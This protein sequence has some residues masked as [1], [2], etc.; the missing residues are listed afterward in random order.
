MRAALVSP[1]SWSFPGGVTRHV[2]ELAAEL[3]AQ[4]HE[5]RVLSPVDPDDRLTRAVHRRRPERR[6]LPDY[7]VP[8]GRT[9]ALAAN[10]AV[11]NLSFAPDAAVRLRNE[12]RAGRFDVVHV[13]E[14]IAPVI[15][16]DACCFDGS[17]VVGTFHVYSTK[18][19]PKGAA[20]VQGARGVFNKLNAR[21]AVSEAARWTGERYF[22]GEYQVI[23]NGVDVGAAP[24]GPRPAADHLRVLFVGR[25]E[26][27]KGLPVLLSAFAGLRRHIPVRLQ[28]A[29]ARPQSVEPL[30]VDLEGGI[31]GVELLGS[32]D[33]RELWGRLHAA[34]VLCAPSLG[35]E[36]FGKQP[37]LAIGG[38]PAEV[39]ARTGGVPST[40]RLTA[41]CVCSGRVFAALGGS[42]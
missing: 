6:P 35:G 31:D 5:V 11:S 24:S 19:L 17:P 41:F 16:W 32:I 20:T 21:I 8:L 23:P 39:I 25:E 40:F 14:P 13:H 9:V 29:G 42:R 36:S 2:E 10:G 30:L 12:L 4:G 22:G 27:R 26:E 38:R 3:I 28:V 33:K 34:D 15:G 18:W 37:T 1:Y 7:L